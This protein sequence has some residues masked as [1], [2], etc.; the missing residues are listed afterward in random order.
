M[1]M[2]ID[3]FKLIRRSLDAFG[4]NTSASDDYIGCSHC[5]QRAITTYTV[6]PPNEVRS[7]HLQISFLKLNQQL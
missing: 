4:I 5:S 1:H 7:R 3:S 6:M 2:M